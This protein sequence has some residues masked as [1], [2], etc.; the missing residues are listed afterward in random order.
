MKTTY[1]AGVVALA[2]S[3]AVW[4]F[5]PFAAA[6]GAKTDAVDA[7]GNLHVPAGYLGKYQFLGTW[8]VAND[9]G[10]GAKQMHVV[11]ASPGTV[12]AY[13]KDGRFPD[14][15]VLVK[16]VYEATTAPMTTGTVSHVQTLKGWFVMVKDDK[17]SHPGNML[18]GDG[19]GWSWFDA[20]AP[21]KTT[22]TDYKSD[23][24]GCHVPAKGT[25]WIYIQGYPGLKR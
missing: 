13:R 22:S 14:G 25:D 1:V 17:N 21:M 20:D 12:A 23:C 15:S 11:Y 3:A 5:T 9:E 18:W 24:L 19:W 8:S 7:G 6:S 16:E 10:K 2:L 4:Q